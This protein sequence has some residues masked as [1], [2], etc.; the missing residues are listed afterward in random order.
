MKY[1]LLS[2]TDQLTMSEASSELWMN[3]R[4]VGDEDP[5]VD[6]SKI[7]GLVLGWS[8]LGAIKAIRALRAY[9]IKDPNRFSCIYR[10]M[11][12]QKWVETNISNIV[13]EIE[14][15][16]GIV[17]ELQTFR[18]TVEKRRT[19]LRTLDVIKPVADVLDN[20]VDL[21]NPDWVILI[22]ILGKKTGISIIKPDDILNIQKEKYQLSRKGH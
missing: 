10:I 2:T 14:I 15:Q 1:N 19:K 12:I 8:S 16:K 9:M 13:E 17:K 6:R 21:E 11:P 7:M 22:N 3:L 5:K 4:S 20:N 18:V